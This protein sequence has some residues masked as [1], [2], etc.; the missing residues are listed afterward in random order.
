MKYRGKI[1]IKDCLFCN[2]QFQALLYKVN[3]GKQKYC[4]LKCFHNN[5]KSKLSHKELDKIYQA[6]F[7]YG[8]N[9]QEYLNLMTIENCQICGKDIKDKK[10]IDHCHSTGMIRGILCNNCNTGLGMF[11]DSKDV[12]QKALNYISQ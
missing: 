1:I 7:R 11:K 2:K 3:I 8:L 6:K 5:R 4:S 10:Y 12:I 9:K